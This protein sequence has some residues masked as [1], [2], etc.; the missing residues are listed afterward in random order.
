MS[1]VAWLVV[2]FVAL[3]AVVGVLVTLFRTARRGTEAELEEGPVAAE[4]PETER[5][6]EE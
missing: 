1:T 4:P 3:V 6:G 2:G 5:S